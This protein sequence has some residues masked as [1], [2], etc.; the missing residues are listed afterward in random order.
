MS[1]STCPNIW[2]ENL[3]LTPFLG[4]K[5]PFSWSKQIVN[6]VVFYPDDG[7]SGPHCLSLDNYNVDTD[8][9]HLF[10]LLVVVL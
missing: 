9:N 2:R 8:H 4:K 3:V 7:S 6:F 1:M 10:P 5:N